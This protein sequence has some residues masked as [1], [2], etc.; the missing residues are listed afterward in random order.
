MFTYI[1]HDASVPL[2]LCVKKPW[3]WKQSPLKREEIG[4]KEDRRG[5]RAA[6]LAMVRQTLNLRDG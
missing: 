6:V 3:S 1:R 4:E 5:A 2:A